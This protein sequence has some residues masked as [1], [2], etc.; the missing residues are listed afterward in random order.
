MIIAGRISGKL[1]LLQSRLTLEWS[2]VLCGVEHP[3]T[4]P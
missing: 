2:V 4:L 1:E 3:R